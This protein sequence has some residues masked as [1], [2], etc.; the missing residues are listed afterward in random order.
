MADQ[1]TN[2]AATEDA[3]TAER[4][5]GIRVFVYGTLKTGHGNH[6]ALRDAT[7]LGTHTLDSGFKMFHLGGFPGVVRATGGTPG[8]P[9]HGEVYLVDESTLQSLDW[10]EGHPNFYEREKVVSTPW[11]R[12]WIYLLREDD[13]TDCPEIESGRW[14]HDG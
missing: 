8:Y 11:K 4:A 10:I 2:D 7:L 12:A 1:V 3:G 14:G 5:E 9:I 6:R 13:V